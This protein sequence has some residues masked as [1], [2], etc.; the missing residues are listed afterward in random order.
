MEYTDPAKELSD[1][2]ALLMEQSNQAGDIYLA[3]EF[4]VTPWSKEFFEILFSLTERFQDII[5]IIDLTEMDADLK[6]DAKNSILQISNAFEKNGL[7]QSW[8]AFGS[9]HLF[10]GNINVLKYMSPEVRRLVK[11]PKLSQEELTSIS[12]DI[13]FLIDELSKLQ[14]KEEDF[15]RQAILSGL[16]QFKFRI[17]HFKWLGCGYTI[18]GLKEVIG[19]YLILEKNIN[20]NKHDDNEYTKIYSKLTNSLKNI[21]E[22]ISFTK[23]IYEKG[24]WILKIYGAVELIAKAKEPV[25]KLLTHIPS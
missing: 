12:V 16:K 22:K 23:D 17:D 5:E 1:L 11:Y 21:S 24:E 18:D 6:L 3:S 13:I 10:A 20:I 4:N 15:I 19:A 9:R 8:E 25:T 2:L 7:I 14:L